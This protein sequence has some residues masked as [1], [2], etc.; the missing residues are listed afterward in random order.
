MLLIAWPHH[1]LA[2][3]STDEQ[4]ANLYFQDRDFEKAAY[5]FEKL[6]DANPS[7]QYYQP[8]LTSY[9]ETGEFKKAE[10]LVKKESKPIRETL[11]SR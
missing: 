8:L 4:L 7:N 1:L 2:Q 9:I 5:Y 6:F 3:S 11:P 10:K